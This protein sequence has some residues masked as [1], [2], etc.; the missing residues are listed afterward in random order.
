M[1]FPR[2]MIIPAAFRVMPASRGRL[3]IVAGV[4]L[5][6]VLGFAAWDAE[7][8]RVT[9]PAR[10][11][12]ENFY[13]DEAGIIAQA[14]ARAID[15]A[16]AALLRDHQVPLI[17]VTISSLAAHNAAG[18]TI[19]R[20]AFELFNEWGIGSE[21]RNYG[22][23][24]MVSKGDRRARIELGAAW[25]HSYNVQAQEIMS[26]LVIPR[27]KE[28][29]FSEG[30]LAGVRGMDAMARGLALPK[31]EQPWW[32]IPLMLGALGLAIAVIVS[33]FKSGRKGWGWALIALLAV[34]LFFLLR[35]AAQA[36]G[37][38]GAFGGGSSGGGGASGSW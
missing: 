31:P 32:V 35:S 36:R 38:G 28:E 33:L 13:V 22:M 19:E 1:H 17:V 5:A 23:L 2:A 3:G 10:P 27:F 26:T 4:V 7:A 16:A 14:E 24:L 15:E 8:Q 20:Y 21:R 29:K 34:V 25:G 37:S 18:Y 6:V 30:I 12:A 9:F 11:P